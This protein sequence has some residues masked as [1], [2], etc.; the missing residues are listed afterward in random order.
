MN[1]HNQLKNE[2]LQSRMREWDDKIKTL[3][4]ETDFL[5]IEDVRYLTNNIEGVPEILA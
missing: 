1:E 3:I 4:V 5:D 2:M